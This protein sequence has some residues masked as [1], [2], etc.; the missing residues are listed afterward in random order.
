MRAWM[1]VKVREDATHGKK[2]HSRAGQAGVT[3]TQTADDAAEVEVRFDID[4]QAETV[5]VSDLTV[6]GG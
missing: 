2:P 3:T 4:N 5:K 1:Q 6:L